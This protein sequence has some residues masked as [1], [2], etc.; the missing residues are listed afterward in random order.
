MK[1]K[2][3]QKYVL[4]LG[5]NRIDSVDSRKIGFIPIENIKRHALYRFNIFKFS[6]NKLE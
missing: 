4:V 6:A 2:V 1:V 3:S 5:D